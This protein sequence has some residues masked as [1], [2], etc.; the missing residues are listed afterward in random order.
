MY[1]IA[2]IAQECLDLAQGFLRH[3]ETHTHTIT[4]VKKIPFFHNLSPVLMP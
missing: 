3:V 1:G 4:N 2:T